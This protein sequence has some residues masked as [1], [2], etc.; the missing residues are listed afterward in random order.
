[1]VAKKAIVVGS[2]GQDG[3]LLCQLLAQKDYRIVEVAKGLSSDI[4]DSRQVT[5]LVA[6]HAPDEIYFLAAYHQS[7][8]ESRADE[9]SLLRAS[10]DVNV[11]ALTN[12]LEAIRSA[13]PASRLFY[14]ASS[15]IFGNPDAT[16]QNES[17]PL[18][19]NN[20]YGISKAA[21]TF[22]CRYYRR[23]H[24]VHA[25]VGILYNHESVYRDRKFISKKIACAVARIK[26]GT[27][28]K[29]VLGNLDAAVDWGYAPDY[30]DAMYRILRLD[31][32]DDYV[33]AT[34][35]LHTV[36]DMAR[37]AFA[38]AGLDFRD[39][40]EADGSLAVAGGARLCGDPSR[41]MQRT[42]WRPSVTFGQMVQEMVEHEL[43]AVR[44]Q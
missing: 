14:A 1:M 36:R 29:V 35:Q 26:A 12:F 41:L 21:G 32:P 25:S 37:I 3:T 39:H 15:H 28:H 24:D 8:E 2:R 9:L 10:V 40:V 13:S 20:L 38:C 11:M 6:T 17:T 44:E 5:D 23:Q 19:P 7:A 43:G 16:P 4:L 34:G 33:I 30:V 42:G 22:A 18:N 27:E 31:T